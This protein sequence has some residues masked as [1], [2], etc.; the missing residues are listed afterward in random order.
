MSRE[1][2]FTLIELLVVIAI[3]AILASLLLPALRSAKDTAA[4]LICISNLRQNGML[5]VMYASDN[6]AHA[7][8]GAYFDADSDLHKQ[9]VPGW[10][11]GRYYFWNQISNNN[12]QVPKCFACPRGRTSM[13]TRYLSETIATSDPYYW[14]N[15]KYLGLRGSHVGSGAFF[16][17]DRMKHP[18]ASGMMFDGGFDGGGVG[19]NRTN[20]NASLYGTTSVYAYI[21]GSAR[22]DSAVVMAP[23]GAVA[24][25]NF[26]LQDWNNRHGPT[27][28]MAHWDGHG[29]KVDAVEAALQYQGTYVTVYNN[30]WYYSDSNP[31]RFFPR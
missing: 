4:Q 9:T 21:P 1:R 8:T 13:G 25:A 20:S 16:Q 27:I 11:S 15:Y 10:Y 28:G 17:Y 14:V 29:E 5:V 3:I 2:T 26:Y 18:S 19:A 22:A 31:A 23:E 6:K 24:G 30:G 7:P 12:G